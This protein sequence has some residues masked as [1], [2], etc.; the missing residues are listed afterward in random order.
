VL[1]V[2]CEVIDLIE[3]MNT[4]LASH[5]HGPT[6]ALNNA[7]AFGNHSANANALAGNLKRIAE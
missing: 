5:N 4:Q 6:P 7:A 2:L 1:Q 3:Q